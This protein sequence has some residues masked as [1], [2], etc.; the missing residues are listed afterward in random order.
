[1]RV[2]QPAE[3]IDPHPPSNPSPHTQTESFFLGGAS[4]SCRRH[5]AAEG[6][7]AVVTAGARDP[8]GLP[9]RAAQLA[10]QDGTE[11]VHGGPTVPGE[12][13][14]QEVED[15][16]DAR[17]D[18][19]LAGGGENR[20]TGHNDFTWPRGV[21]VVLI[22]VSDPRIRPITICSNHQRKCGGDILV[23]M[24]LMISAWFHPPKF[25]PLGYLS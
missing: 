3:P 7:P 17:D 13:Q 2:S 14:Q 11:E 16:D 1:M 21:R 10:A 18:K 23:Y 22:K 8:Q 20:V 6:V 9:G 25:D 15:R 5:L 19:H 24:Y 4:W 12:D